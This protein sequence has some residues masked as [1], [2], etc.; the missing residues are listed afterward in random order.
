MVLRR[1]GQLSAVIG[2]LLLVE[3][4]AWSA[5]VP[6]GHRAIYLLDAG[7]KEH[8]IGTVSFS[9]PTDSGAV[10]YTLNVETEHFSDHFLS[11]KEMKCLEGK[12]LMC[13]IPYP[14]DNPRTVTASD[15][16]WLEHDLLFMFKKPT[17]FGANFWNGIYYRMT[18]TDD[19]IL[20]E[21]H[22]VDLNNLAAPPDDLTVPPFGEYDVTGIN[23]KSRWLPT[24]IIR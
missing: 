1:L 5:G 10:A 2:W 4:S 7:Q 20:G 14:Y 17:E 8:R 11:M 13:R 18:V 21:A 23:L 24:L 6:L 16:R 9:Q 19:A 22:A 12:E 15:L 3:S